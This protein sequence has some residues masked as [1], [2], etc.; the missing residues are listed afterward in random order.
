M[1]FRH[2]LANLQQE[3]IEALPLFVFADDGLCNRTFAYF[4]HIEYTDPGLRLRLK[5]AL[6]R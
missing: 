5:E 3:I 6:S 2:T 1:A 4:G